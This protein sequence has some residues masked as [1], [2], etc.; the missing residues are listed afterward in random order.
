MLY[1]TIKFLTN[2]FAADKQLY[3]YVI[4]LSSCKI[5]K[6]NRYIIIF[7]EDILKPYTLWIMYRSNLHF[8]L[9]HPLIY[10]ICHML[11]ILLV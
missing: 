6:S 2:N 7:Y 10:E 4:K 11:L 5:Y 8:K 9:Q 1:N 3:I